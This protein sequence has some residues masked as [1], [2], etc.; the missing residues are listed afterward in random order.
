MESVMEKNENNINSSFIRN[1]GDFV[2]MISHKNELITLNKVTIA[3]DS[4]KIRIFLNGVI[5]NNNEDQLIEGFQSQGIDYIKQIEGSFVIFL[6]VGTQF[7]ILTDRVNSKKAFYAF[8]ENVWYVSNNIDALPKDK[9]H[10]S[11]DG[12]ACYLANGAMFNDLT[13]F[14]EIRS[15]N[16]ASVTSFVNGQISAQSYWDFKFE[17]S[18]GSIFQQSQYQKEL[19]LLLIESVKR[20]YD[21]ALKTAISLSS[22][23]DSR[24]ILG[25]LRNKI[26]APNMSCISY[27]LTDN[28]KRDTDADVAKELSAQCGYPHQVLVSYKGNLIDQL[29]NNAKEGKCLSNF[30]DELDAWHTLAASNQF[31]EL[32]VGDEFFGWSNLAQE[33]KENLLESVKIFGASGISRLEPYLSKKIYHQL[34]QCLNKLTDDIY[35]KTNAIPDDND[36]EDFLYLDQRI[37]HVLMPWR[38][39]FSSQVGFVHNPFMDGTILEFMQKLPPHLRQN[40][41]FYLKTT[42]YMFPD[43]FSINKATSS[44]HEVNWQ[45]ELQNQKGSLILLIQDTD[46]RLDEVI[47]KKEVMD[48]INGK[49]SI[50]T[51]IKTFTLTKLQLLGRKN[52]FVDKLLRKLLTVPGL[53]QKG[54]SIPRD[55]LI[56]RLFLIRI[57]LSPSSLDN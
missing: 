4:R 17:Y 50:L 8:I 33:S 2:F 37:N 20:R 7:Y 51:K 9:C 10:L 48:L 6:M 11:L 54:S 3:S 31:S 47:S 39:F 42:K 53:Y 56:L 30:C 38:E 22:G 18:A 1:K 16:R 26:I 43:L 44:G 19:E 12:I 55:K 27:A 46:S 29:K 36:K 24:A 13:L 23:Y 49:G 40:K 14:Q 21:P 32:F 34:R 45:E 28:P 25:I 52:T 15:A 57:Y 41:S 35:E 5:Y